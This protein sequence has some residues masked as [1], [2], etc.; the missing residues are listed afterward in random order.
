MPRL[1]RAKGKNLP[2]RRSRSD[3]AAKFDSICSLIS[4]K[5]RRENRQSPQ[6]VLKGNN[7]RGL[8][9]LQNP[10]DFLRYVFS[11]AGKFQI[12]R[13]SFRIAFLQFNAG[14]LQKFFW[15][16]FGNES[17]RARPA[18]EITF[19][20]EL[21]VSVDDGHPGHAELRCQQARGGQLSGRSEIRR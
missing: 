9:V 2:A 20:Q 5:R 18:F 16:M 7:R 14:R 21:V 11:I 3:C 8:I 19:R 12:A 6:P 15:Q 17:S 10:A 13:R 4:P 1:I